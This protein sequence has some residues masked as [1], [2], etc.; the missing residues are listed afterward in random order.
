MGCSEDKSVQIKNENVEN[1]IKKKEE[2]NN[3]EEIK[4]SKKG[5]K[6]QNLEQKDDNRISENKYV[7]KGSLQVQLE[8]INADLDKNKK[9]EIQLQLNKMMRN[10]QK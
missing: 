10:G 2:I 7:M 1:K 9:K 8:E 6:P 3:I 5:N 4:I